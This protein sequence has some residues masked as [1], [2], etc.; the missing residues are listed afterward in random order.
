MSKLVAIGSMAARLQLLLLLGCS[1]GHEPA[2]P[3]VL[4]IQK[5]P[6]ASG[7]GQS[8]STG[9]ILPQPLVVRVDDR[10][11]AAVGVWVHWSPAPDAGYATADSSQT[12]S[13]GAARVSWRMPTVA[14]PAL[15]T[16]SVAGAIGSPLVFSATAYPNFP[17]LLEHVFGDGAVASAGSAL[18][19][20]VRVGDEFDNDFP[21][22]TVYWTL[23]SGPAQL[24]AASSVTGSD[25][26]ATMTVTLGP[27]TGQVRVEASHPSVGVG[28]PV[29]MD[30]T[31][32]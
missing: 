9:H 22:T 8:W 14:G 15:L 28:S 4:T 6:T 31:V 30:L 17:F 25:G 7:D 21:G 10:G 27:G 32:Q 20:A 19:L 26:V 16:A 18:D 11:L 29:V 24:A 2:G 13:T 3:G 1:A 23:V 12:D 5:D